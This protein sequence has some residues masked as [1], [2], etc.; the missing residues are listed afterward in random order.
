MSLKMTFPDKIFPE[1][2][3]KKKRW[4]RGCHSIVNIINIHFKFSCLHFNF[5]KGIAVE[6]YTE[7]IRVK[8]NIF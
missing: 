2:D 4:G 7:Q 8:I 3:F 5:R 1:E 6:P